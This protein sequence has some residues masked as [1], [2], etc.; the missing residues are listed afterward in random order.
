MLTDQEFNRIT[1]A[2]RRGMLELDLILVPFVEQRLRDLDEVDLQ[3]YL[4][5]LESED[6]DL[7][8]W[9][10]G[11]GKPEDSELAIIVDKIIAHARP[12]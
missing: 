6:N 9:F 5:L 3:R 10:L 11:R 8:A 2:S 4:D 7:F 12:A 1:W